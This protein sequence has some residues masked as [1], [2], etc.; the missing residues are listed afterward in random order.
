[1]LED[2]DLVGAVILIAKFKFHD[3]FDI[4]MVIRRLIEEKNNIDAAK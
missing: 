4:G 3:N 1:M 2:G